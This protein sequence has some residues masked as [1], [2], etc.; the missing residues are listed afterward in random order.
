MKQTSLR[1][2]PAALAA[3]FALPAVAADTFQLG[4]IEVVGKAVPAT[5]N[6][7]AVITAS[8]LEQFNRDTVGQAVALVPGMS[9]S[10]NSRNEDIVLSAWLRCSRGAA[11]HRRH[12][13]LCAL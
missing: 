11:V 4:T 7:E 2:L 9:L 1:V 5:A 10:H 6:A 3:A 8:E 13:D 12:S